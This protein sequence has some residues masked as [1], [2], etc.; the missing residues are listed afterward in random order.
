MYLLLSFGIIYAQHLHLTKHCIQRV[1]GVRRTVLEG[2]L[3]VRCCLLYLFVNWLVDVMVV[4]VVVVVV[5]L[6]VCKMER[7]FEL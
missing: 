4:V 7:V 5:V 3:C 6:V 2:L 1:T